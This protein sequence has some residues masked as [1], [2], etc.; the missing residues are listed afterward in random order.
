MARCG[1]CGRT[2]KSSQSVIAHLRFCPAYKQQRPRSSAAPRPLKALTDEQH[3]QRL[4]GSVPSSAQRPAASPTLEPLPAAPRPTPRPDPERARERRALLEREEQREAQ[5]REAECQRANE[6]R[7]R[8]ERTRGMIQHIKLLVVDCYFPSDP[9]PM[10]AIGEAKKQIEH[11]LFSLPILD[12][13]L[14]ELQQIASGVRERVYAPYRRASAASTVAT[15]P[16]RDVTPPTVYP[17]QKEMVMPMHR[18]FSG[19][20]FCPRCDEEFALDRVPE[21]EAICPNCRVALEEFEADEG[22]DDGE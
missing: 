19:D 6:Q 1:F 17:Q 7:R 10:E 8:A 22:D 20:F 18:M 15:P 13:P 21:N 3:I 4:L 11:E 5:E 9:V 12:L 14:L 2:F 16:R